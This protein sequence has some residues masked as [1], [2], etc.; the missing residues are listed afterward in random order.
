MQCAEYFCT[1]IYQYTQMTFFFVA[2]RFMYNYDL[3]YA[4]AKG[5]ANCVRVFVCVC[6]A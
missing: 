2:L 5:Y 6:V 4:Y 1:H 3:I